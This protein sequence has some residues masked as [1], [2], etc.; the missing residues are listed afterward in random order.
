[1]FPVLLDVCIAS[2]YGIAVSES[3][4]KCTGSESVYAVEY[5]APKTVIS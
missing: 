5:S 3:V 2:G 4:R 1:M